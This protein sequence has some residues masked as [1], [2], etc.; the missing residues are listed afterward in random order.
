[1]TGREFPA[2]YRLAARRGA[3]VEIAR[4]RE[5]GFAGPVLEV[6]VGVARLRVDTDRVVDRYPSDLVRVR[7]MFALGA[8]PR[9][10]VFVPHLRRF[11]DTALGSPDVELGDAAFDARFTVLADD[12]GAVR[13]VWTPARRDRLLRASA[14]AVG[15][16]GSALI[17]VVFTDLDDEAAIDGVIELAGELAQHPV[18]ALDALRAVPGAEL[19]PGTGSWQHRSLPRAVVRG[20]AEV[21]LGPRRF[22]DRTAMAAWTTPSWE[23]PDSGS[24][25]IAG[26]VVHGALPVAVTPAG[27]AHLAATGDCVV[28]WT[29]RELVLDWG[30]LLVSTARLRAGAG[31]LAELGHPTPTPY[32]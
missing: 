4:P 7:A 1:M 14:A 17:A 27:A 18:E 28:S 9:F 12:P 5:L 31:L 6:D 21:A 20:R 29:P 15:S 10:A 26:H 32:R 23:L 25:A 8:A 13:A 16:D 3:A 19:R 11:V 2:W 24:V 30:G 22:G